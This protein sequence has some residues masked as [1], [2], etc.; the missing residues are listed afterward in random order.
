MKLEYKG[1]NNK[2]KIMAPTVA[3]A[4]ERF[5]GQN[6]EFRE[7]VEQ[8]DFS[9]CMKTISAGVGTSISDVEIIKRAVEYYFKG[10]TVHF[11][12]RIEMQGDAPVKAEKKIISLEDFL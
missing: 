4:L 8:G 5:C 2:A 11:D 9:E 7:A 3:E 6:A 1:T 10:A 12:M